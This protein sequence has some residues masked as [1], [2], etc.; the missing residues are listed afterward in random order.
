ME[1]AYLNAIVKSAYFP[2]YDPYFAGGYINYYYH[3]LHLVSILI[4]VTG[5]VPQV[6]FNLAI[7]TLFALTVVNAFSL[8]YNLT[9]RYLWGVAAPVFLAIMGNLDGLR[10]IVERLGDLGGLEFRSPIPGVGG[11]VRAVPGL[12]Q[13]LLG[14][15]AL[16]PFDYWRSTR[17]IPFTINEFPFF[18]FLFADLHP[19]MISIPFAILLLA[20]VFCVL[21]KGE[22]S[23]RA[24]GLHSYLLF[25][26]LALSLGAVATI[27][28]WDLPTYFLIILGAFLLRAW[29]QR[30]RW[31]TAK[32]LSASLGIVALGLLLYLPFFTYYQPLHVGLGLVRRRTEIEPFLTIWGFFLFLIGGYLLLSLRHRL[33]GRGALL[34]FGFVSPAVLVFLLLKEWVLALLF[35]LL[36][37]AGI[38]TLSDDSQPERRFIHLLA[39]LGLGILLGCEVVYMRD[40]L[41]GGEYHRMN[42]IFK[43]YIQAWVL[44]SVAGAAALSQLWPHLRWRKLWQGAFLALFLA[45][46][47]YTVFG[48]QA[49]V[50]DRFPGAKPSPGTLDGLAF[51][52]VGRYTWPDESNPIELR[53][54]YEVI[55]WFLANVEGTPVVAE[56]PLPYYREGG[57]RVASY[58]GLPTLVGAHQN[59]QRYGWMVAEREAEARSL[60]ES[61]DLEETKALIEELD[62]TYIYVGQL[63]RTVYPARSLAKFDTL[64]EQ[65][66]LE[67]A[68][69]NPKVRVYKVRG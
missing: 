22:L 8:G 69:E 48:A 52:T 42:T 29:A 16:P 57:L 54:D 40:F 28:T 38:V 21:R 63:E 34:A 56:A 64:L 61:T 62:V 45:S 60:Y 39:F 15:G 37:L 11:L 68:Y 58:T 25:F 6:A 4:K 19:H 20:L 55:Q 12:L 67:L 33:R 17:V 66:Y 59:E 13:S 50:R 24:F 1:F 47:I 14:R 3:G 27:N 9:R 53:Y 2:P 23:E 51:M 49:R 26:I 46:T 65:G 35:P 44:L 36:I 41:Q 5:I 32:A 31:A 7:P 43:F 18:S 10:Q 30:G